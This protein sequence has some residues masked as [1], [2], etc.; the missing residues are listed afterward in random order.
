MFAATAGGIYPRVEEAMDAMGQGFDN[1]YK[2][3]K[4]STA[5][6]QKRYQRYKSLGAFVEDDLK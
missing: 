6:Y 2:P 5:V 1:E 4:P 3:N